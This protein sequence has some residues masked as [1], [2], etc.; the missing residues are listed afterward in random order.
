MV[1]KLSAKQETGV[2]FLC[3]EDPL[4]GEM[5]NHSSILAWEIPWTEDSGRL[6]SMG[7]QRLGHDL[8]TKPLPP[9][10]YPVSYVEMSQK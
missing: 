5:A 10:F 2:L 3:W 8:A 7:S 1:N 9:P 4:E 6:Q